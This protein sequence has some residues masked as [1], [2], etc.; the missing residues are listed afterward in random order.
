ME[1]VLILKDRL[2]VVRS[3]DIVRE[4]EFSKPSISVA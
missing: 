1:T 2:G 3:I 4:K